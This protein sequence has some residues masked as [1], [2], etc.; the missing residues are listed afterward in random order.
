MK[1]FLFIT[2]VI[3]IVA[4]TSCKPEISYEDW[5]KTIKP[6]LISKCKLDYIDFEEAYL[7]AWDRIPYYMSDDPF[8][9]QQIDAVFSLF[10]SWAETLPSYMDILQNEEEWIDMITH[11][12]IENN[13]VNYES[14]WVYQ[15]SGIVYDFFINSWNVAPDFEFDY[16]VFKEKNGDRLFFESY[17]PTD[18]KYYV[19][20]YKEGYYNIGEI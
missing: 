12:C 4:L 3:P 7:E 6:A 19:V 9:E 14:D 8:Y 11:Y 16:P 17:C 13:Y 5:N 10:A 15:V 2:I 20:T 1:K 18:N